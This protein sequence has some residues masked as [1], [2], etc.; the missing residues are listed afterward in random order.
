MSNDHWDEFWEQG[1]ITTFGPTLKNNYTGQLRSFWEGIFSKVG[2]DEIIL[3]LAT[4]NGALACLAYETANSKGSQPGIYAID[5]ARIP[6]DI[7][8]PQNIKEARK[9]IH[10]FGEMPCESLQFEDRQFDLITSQFGIEYGDWNKS[11]QEVHRTLKNDSS[12]H[13]VC[14]ARESSL[15][16]SAHRELPIY[17]SAL[18]E[19]NIFEAAVMF[20]TN[21]QSSS[22]KSSAHKAE[23][24]QSVNQLQALF[25]EEE[26][27]RMMLTDLIRCLKLLNQLPATDVAQML[28]A[29]KSTYQ[30]AYARQ[31]DMV[32]AALDER[33]QEQILRTSKKI[34]FHDAMAKEFR[35]NNELIGIYIKLTK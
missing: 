8:A 2:S 35:Q 15:L 27:F 17:R 1:Y 4:G 34:G 9:A 28:S 12:A 21:H 33:A 25:S 26:L 20:A 24:N 22:G 18:E 23:L 29:R 3:D 10:F 31:R 11:L 16:K 32:E 13:F 19:K 7:D 5:A 30:A 14:H 6:S